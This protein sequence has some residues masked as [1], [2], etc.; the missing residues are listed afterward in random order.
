MCEWI[1]YEVQSRFIDCSLS[2]HRI[3]LLD[4][5]IH[6]LIKFSILDVL[7]TTS[8]S[9]IIFSPQEKHANELQGTQ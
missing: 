3:M 7:L 6:L 9:D 8:Y 2:W 4:L 1:E 5:N